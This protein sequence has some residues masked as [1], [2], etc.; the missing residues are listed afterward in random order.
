MCAFID[1]N[2][3]NRKNNSNGKQKT[4]QLFKLFSHRLTRIVIEWVSEKPTAIN[5]NNSDVAHNE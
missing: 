2:K 5:K 4:V 3:I 1:F